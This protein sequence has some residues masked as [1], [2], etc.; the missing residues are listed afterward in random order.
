MKISILPACV[1]ALI[2]LNFSAKSQELSEIRALRDESVELMLSHKF[3]QS[4]AKRA[5][6]LKLA[7]KALAAREARFGK[8]SPE[9]IPYLKITGQLSFA[10][11]LE[12]ALSYYRRAL[13]IAE[14][15]YGPENAE[16]A[17]CLD[18]IASPQGS[19]KEAKLFRERAYAMR[20]KLF[21]DDHPETAKSYCHLGDQARQ[22]K[23]DHMAQD[24]LNR[25]L[26]IFERSLTPADAERFM[27]VLDYLGMVLQMANEGNKTSAKAYQ[28]RVTA[29]KSRISS[30]APADDIAM[31]RAAAQSAQVQGT[32][33][34]IS[35][36]EALLAALTKKH[37]EKAANLL[38]PLSQ[39][40]SDYNTSGQQ[41][42]AIAALDRMLHLDLGNGDMDAQVILGALQ[43]ASDFYE[44]IGDF[45][46]A[47]PLRQQMTDTLPK[48]KQHAQ[49]DALNLAA[50][51]ID[52][53]KDLAKIGKSNESARYL[54]LARLAPWPKPTGNMAELLNLRPLADL[55]YQMNR[56]KEAAALYEEFLAIFAKLGLGSFPDN[57]FIRQ[58]LGI[59]R[60]QAGDLKAAQ[61][62][63]ER[64]RKA[65]RSDDS[66][67]TA[68]LTNLARNEAWLAQEQGRT[69]AAAAFA[70]EWD[71]DH[72]L[73]LKRLF[74]FATERQRLAFK[75]DNDP[76]SL[77]A[78]LGDANE[79][80]RAVL[81]YKGIVLDSLIEESRQQDGKKSAELVQAQQELMQAEFRLSAT[82]GRG[83]DSPKDPRTALQEKVEKLQTQA[84]MNTSSLITHRAVDVSVDEVRHV[85]PADSALVE[86]I[87]YR[88]HLGS[89]HFEWR[90]G[91]VII[92]P[93]D[94]SHWVAL[95]AAQDIDK[96]YEQ[97]GKALA[98]EDSAFA[99]ASTNLR[100]AVW[101]PIAKALPPATR[102]VLLSP[103]GVTHM[104][105]FAA[106]VDE[107]DHFLTEKFDFR[108]LGSGRDLLATAT[109]SSAKDI[110]LFANPQFKRAGLEQT[111]VLADA[112]QRAISR[113]FELDELPG[114]Q[115]EADALSAL[116]GSLQWSC[117]NHL[118][119]DAR[120]S[121]LMKLKSPKILHIATHGFFLPSDPADAS[122]SG[123]LPMPANPMLRSGLA[124][125]GAQ[126]TFAA[127]NSG[128]TFPTADDGVV[129]AYEAS[130]LDLQH[131]L[132]VTLSACDTGLG[133]ARVGEG[134]FGLRRSFLQAGAQNLMVTLWPINDET[135][136]QFMTDFYRETLPAEAPAKAITTVQKQALLRIRSELGLRRAVLDAGGFIL[137]SKGK[138]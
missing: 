113:A 96:A 98:G 44:F 89:L 83:A 55:Y 22:A 9:I 111:K 16:V 54:E 94:E 91:A 99:V 17:E 78:T 101:D 76:F 40:A 74:A 34:S 107:S 105:S 129:T 67:R 108:Y 24:Y 26:V 23:N 137:I 87:R 49:A 45:E 126:D 27:P 95:G 119:L 122:K 118:S 75:Q 29:V 90:Y 36:N 115:Q 58:R 92:L 114:T 84:T 51:Q 66:Q 117:A 136:V 60:H 63:Y 48:F 102:T 6:G 15:T 65:I 135:T 8:D 132:L 30:M 20:R 124:L 11:S 103:D 64:A 28:Q 41:D 79:V 57:V 14:K 85:L 3:E 116:A 5:Q 131:T 25:A 33:A 38:P 81:R 88:H 73:R 12:V 70:H 86:I 120:E 62:F 47:T 93:A 71:Q 2:A 133:E 37:G 53:A 127:W 43:A 32:A 7:K 52:L 110:A 72:H 61:T 10:T 134:V 59:I 39:L 19:N 80:A 21:G 100:A 13:S 35:A 104:V 123:L 56:P 125:A 50:A 31:L 121:V 68:W 82:S 128:N 1:V 18:N 112:T 42:K 130:T 97:F 109:H 4:M 106:L 138:P 69:Q 77:W 46:N